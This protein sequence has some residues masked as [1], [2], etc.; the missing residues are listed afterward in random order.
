MTSISCEA[1]VIDTATLKLH[2][3][4]DL[5]SSNRV[6]QERQG[7]LTG[8]TVLNVE[9]INDNIQKYLKI[10]HIWDTIFRLSDQVMAVITDKR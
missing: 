1:A 4:I 3:V 2:G 9:P 8:D 10:T 6:A 5:T 7:T